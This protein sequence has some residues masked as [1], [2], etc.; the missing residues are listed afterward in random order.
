MAKQKI[1]TNTYDILPSRIDYFRRRMDRI[2]KAADSKVPPIPFT[3]TEHPAT[4]KPLEK[5]LIGRAEA[6]RVP[7]SRKLPSGQWI[8]DIIPIT[9][10]YGELT[11]AGF[12]YIGHIK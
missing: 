11:D 5:M 4:T 8:R 7:D 10:E 9:V 3:Y 1:T 6:G 2:K 12:E